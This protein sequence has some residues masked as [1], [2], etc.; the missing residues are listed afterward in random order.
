MRTLP[1]KKGY[2]YGLNTL[3]FIAAFFIIAKHIQHNQ[4]TVGLPTL[5]KYAFLS[6]GGVSFFFTLSG[7]LITYIRLGEYDK[8]K[9]I[10]LKKF[11]VNRF[12]RLAPVYYLVILAGVSLYT[13]VLPSLDVDFSGNFDP[14]IAFLFYFFFFPNVYNSFYHVGGI[15]NITWSI[16]IQEQFYLYF[17]PF[18]K[19]KMKY[20]QIFLWLIIITSALIYILISIE[21][22]P[23]SKNIK[24]L[25]KN[26]LNLHFMGFGALM[27]YYLKRHKEKLLSLFIFSKKWPQFILAFLIVGWYSIKTY[28]PV[29]DAVLSL[30]LSL[31]FGW[32]IINVSSN[33]NNIIK[34][35]YKILDWIGQR[36]YG[37]YMYHMFVIYAIS[38]FFL[39]TSLFLNNLILYQITYYCLV[40]G[41]TVFVASLSYKYFE[42]PIIKWHKKRTGKKPEKRIITY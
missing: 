27:G 28:S 21:S 20:I 16:G 42:T 17:L 14:F 30:P 5:P 8:H 13:F 11:F 34:I 33:P 7:F 41:I 10:N 3:R 39:K 19:S 31:L 4:L 25:I 40:L 24:K 6:K 35:D 32:L 22:V 2:L 38:F 15:L 36:T 9:T 23:L 1:P 37:I 12:F 29:L 18:I 26:T